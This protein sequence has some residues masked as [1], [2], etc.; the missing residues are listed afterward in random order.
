MWRYLVD[1]YATQYNWNCNVTLLY[2]LHLF[3]IPQATWTRATIPELNSWNNA[4]PWRIQLPRKKTSFQTGQQLWPK[5]INYKW[6]KLIKSVTFILLE[7]LHDIS[8]IIYYSHI[9][10][11]YLIQ[12]YYCYMFNVLCIDILYVLY[13]YMF[14]YWYIKN[15]IRIY[16]I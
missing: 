6:N 15:I 7:L 2:Y 8:R 13:I 5:T 12:Y 9:S 4:R 11:Y 1:L 3:H 10:R 14:L 16:S